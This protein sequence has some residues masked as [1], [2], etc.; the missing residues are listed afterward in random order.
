MQKN[1][2]KEIEEEIIGEEDYP[3]PEEEERVIEDYNSKCRCPERTCPRYANCK[4][5]QKFHKKRLELTYCG[6]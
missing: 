5:C 1:K 3:F 6:K 2:E 4:E